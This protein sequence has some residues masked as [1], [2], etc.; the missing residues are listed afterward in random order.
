MCE[1]QN[2]IA[3]FG[4]TQ[5]PAYCPNVTLSA[6]TE[7]VFQWRIQPRYQTFDRYWAFRFRGSTAVGTF[8]LEIPN[9]TSVATGI[10]FGTDRN[11][12]S[13]F[14]IVKELASQ[15]SS[16]ENATVAI[17]PTTANMVVEEIAMYEVPRARLASGGSDRGMDTSQNHIHGP[18]QHSRLSPL[19]SS[20]D[21][22]S[23]I[24][25]RCS[26]VQWA[27][28]HLAGGASTTSFAATFSG[29]AAFTVGAL[30]ANAAQAWANN[31]ICVLGRFDQ[32]AATAANLA[33][34]CIAWK[35]GAGN[36]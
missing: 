19:F 8:A 10:G 3:G 6:A 25:Q 35:S 11:A 1:L 30:S 32:A 18:I 28:P 2:W 12:I 31:G 17:T 20:T 21:S 9:A 24:G 13:N 4:A 33:A 22:F 23:E 15:S 5:I 29:T 27:V 34:S 26:L 16:T 14:T 7:Y 36:G